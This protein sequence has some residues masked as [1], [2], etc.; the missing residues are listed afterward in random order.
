MYNAGLPIPP[1]FAVT[2]QAYQKFIKET[3][4]QE[5]IND[6]LKQISMEDSEQLQRV[7]KE[8]RELILNAEM[9]EE[10]KEEILEAYDSMNVDEDVYNKAGK[11]ALDIIKAGRDAPYVAV[12]SS[13]TAE[14][15][16]DASF[17]GQ[18]ETFL[19]IK[20][21]KEL[22]KSVQKCWASLFTARAIYYRE[23]NNFDHMKVFI[24][25]IVQKMVNSKKSG[26]MFSINPATNNEN[27]IVIEA[28]FGL[29]EA[30]V[31][32]SLNPDYYVVEKPS[33]RIK[34]KEIKKQGFMLVRDTQS[35]GN[36]KKELT[37]EQ[38]AQ[39]V[40]TDDEIIGLAKLAV[41][42]ENHYEKPQD[43]EWA[44]ENHK[45]YIVQSRPVTTLKKE[46][47]KEEP[48]E[49]TE[50]EIL[51]KGLGVS[52]QVGSGPVRLIQD[53]SEIDKVKKGD[54][55][56]TKMTN[57][58]F[59]VG[60]Q[61]AAG[62]VTNEGGTTCFSGRTKVL[63]N[64]GFMTMEE[65]YER[66]SEEKKLQTLSLDSKN[67]RI[68]WKPIVAAYK[69]KSNLWKVQISPTLRSTQNFLEVT[70][71]HQFL[72]LKDR[73]L[74]KKR[75]DEIIKDKEGV[76]VVDKITSLLNKN[77]VSAEEAYLSG[78]IFSDG[79]LSI[80]KQG[81]YVTTFTQSM[82]PEKKEFI[83]TVNEGFNNL[84]N[85]NLS[86][87]CDKRGEVG[88]FRCY[89]K[90]VHS[91]LLEIKTNLI[92]LVLSMDETSLLSLI[93]GFIDGDGSIG[94]HQVFITVGEAKR[95]SLE[96]LVC[97]C[98]RLGIGF[99][100]C[101][102]KTDN[103]Y[104]MNFTEGVEK[105]LKHCKRVKGDLDKHFGNKFFLSKQIVSDIIDDVNHRGRVK[106]PYLTKNLMMSDKYLRKTIIPKVNSKK[107]EFE[108]L[109]K[110]NF[111]MNRI[112]FEE[113]IGEKDVFN[114]EIFADNELDHNYIVFTE[115]LT[116]IIVGNCHAAIVSREMGVAAVV[117]TGNA[118]EVLK[119]DQEITVD[120]KNGVVYAGLIK[121]KEVQTE[122][123]TEAV[124]HEDTCVE[125]VTLVKVN[126]DIPELAE[127][128]AATGADGVGLLRCEFLILGLKEH[129]YYLI[130]EG[131]KAELVDHLANGIRKIAE[132]FRDKPVWYRTLDAPTDEFRKMKGG[133][134]EPHEA[135]P[136]MGWRSIRRDLDQPELLK[137]QFEAIKRVHDEGLTNIGIMIPLVTEID[138]IRRSKEILRETGLEPLEEIEFGVMV[139]TPASVQII[140]EICQEKIDFISF[141]TNDLTQFTLAVDRDS[142]NIQKL[143]NELHPAVLRQMKHVIKT[144]KKYGVETSI[145]GQAASKSE[146][147]EFLV[148]N[149]ID[150][151]SANIDAVQQIKHTVYKAERKLLL[152]AARK[153]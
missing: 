71:D 143:Y 37:P 152:D 129:P 93:G 6:K 108:K 114:I 113:N 26:V 124:H 31:S 148:K 83:Q 50:R 10:I 19:N 48:Q 49:S 39:Q 61:K 105:L 84:Y 79:S 7:A 134:D 142:A 46:E 146:M 106:H 35:G 15:L 68:C 104:I 136:M 89:K 87:Y 36:I 109:L 85:E 138:Q 98:L 117:G 96:A 151:I 99:N 51:V 53:A 65:L 18:Q 133:E 147:A 57:P 139:E 150:S 131:R 145:C 59:V 12:R 86:L 33:L 126:V 100:I 3:N 69:R 73:K 45:L 91:R 149:G 52:P 28:A 80:N 144:C 54:V 1:G 153:K 58:D 135:N 4:L 8:I 120:G 95:E 56:V 78:A 13:A 66:L 62:I 25:V 81:G 70:P 67:N 116:P 64:K 76:L 119:E 23:K 44:I 9:P 90:D 123:P 63:T 34:Q 127:K 17:A 141:G 72:T 103:C 16:P 29:G 32:G 11:E 22:L 55:L 130:K 5:E 132:N 121:A 24:S 43:M 30:V 128:A 122:Q 102:N 21:N 107:K 40:L 97:A 60:M 38:E 42:I 27:E 14:D 47:P 82:I 118:T 111:R 140:E 41:Q 137:A 88:L 115:N 101:K 94:H 92:P 77:K 20:G 75:V 125:T 112:K 110:S 2:A 74:I